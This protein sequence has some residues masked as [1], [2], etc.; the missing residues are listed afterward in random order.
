LTLATGQ[1]FHEFVLLK[2]GNVSAL[3]LQAGPVFRN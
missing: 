3:P 1:P 2:E